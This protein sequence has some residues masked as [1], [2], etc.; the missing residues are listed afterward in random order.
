MAL[1]RNAVELGPQHAHEIREADVHSMIRS[2]L[3]VLKKKAEDTQNAD[4]AFFRN[5]YSHLQPA[6]ETR[7]L[8]YAFDEMHPDG[9]FYFGFILNNHQNPEY[10]SALKV[11]N[12]QEP[13]FKSALIVHEGSSF[14]RVW[15]ELSEKRQQQ[16]LLSLAV[17]GVYLNTL[18]DLESPDDPDPIRHILYST[19]DRPNFTG[20]LVELYHQLGQKLEIPQETVEEMIPLAMREG[21]VTLAQVMNRVSNKANEQLNELRKEGLSLSQAVD[22]KS[23]VVDYLQKLAQLEELTDQPTQVA[24]NLIKQFIQLRIAHMEQ[25]ANSVRENP[26]KAPADIFL[27]F[28]FAAQ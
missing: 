24:R 9:P 12:A 14:K 4:A 22:L 18:H 25:I 16:L 23:P 20:S 28:M 2:S 10:A 19:P 27:D 1:N 3:D 26:A 15:T 13:L 21:D 5:L 11:L 6:Y 7:M 8:G 17:Y